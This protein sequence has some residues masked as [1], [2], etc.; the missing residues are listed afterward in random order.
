MSSLLSGLAL[1]ISITTAWLTLFRH[2]CH[3]CGGESLRAGEV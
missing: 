1:A 3:P 2:G